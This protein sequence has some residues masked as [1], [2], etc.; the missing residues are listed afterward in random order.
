MGPEAEIQK[1]ILDYLTMR[2]IYHYRNNTGRRGGVSYG[3]VGSADI[4]GILPNG[5][6]L[7][8][9]V[10]RPGGVASF[11]QLEFLA[12]IAKNGG[13]AF[14]SDNLQTV[15]DHLSKAGF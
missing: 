3:F 8:I 12:N 4:I 14:A 7:A 9:E 15:I 2:G 11:E 5:R 13:V 10:K 1:L 6:F